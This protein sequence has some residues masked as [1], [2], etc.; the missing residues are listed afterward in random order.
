M[1]KLGTEK[2]PAIVRV[3]TEERA[4]EIAS[5]CAEHGWQFIIGFE[6]D[7]PEDVSDVDK[8]L[9]R[10]VQ[11][12]VE[13]RSGV[14]TR[15]HVAVVKSIKNVVK[16]NPCRLFLNSALTPA[17]RLHLSAPGQLAR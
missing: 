9:N 15:V 2:K 12:T 16:N 4:K 13:K 17:Q 10:S 11:K 7:K 14:M 8:L 1:A 6:P 3:Q 5:I